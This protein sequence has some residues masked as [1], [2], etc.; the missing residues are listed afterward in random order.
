MAARRTEEV[1][2]LFV[3]EKKVLL[4]LEPS[5]KSGSRSIRWFAGGCVTNIRSAAR[6][7]AFLVGKLQGRSL[8]VRKLTVVTDHGSNAD[9]K[10]M[11]LVEAVE[12]AGFF[13]S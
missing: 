1:G 8:V 3:N 13:V 7:I 6:D 9:L 4:K 5:K 12:K 11:R 2:N 10:K